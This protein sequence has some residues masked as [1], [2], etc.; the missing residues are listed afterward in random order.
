M[1]MDNVVRGLPQVFGE[2]GLCG[3][4]EIHDGYPVQALPPVQV[5]ARKGC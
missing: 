4:S 5:C 2:P 3:A 1:Y